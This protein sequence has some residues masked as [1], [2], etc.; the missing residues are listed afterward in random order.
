M[1]SRAR[2]RAHMHTQLSQLVDTLS[3]FACA[4]EANTLQLSYPGPEGELVLE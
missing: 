1:P 3:T 2:A 4:S